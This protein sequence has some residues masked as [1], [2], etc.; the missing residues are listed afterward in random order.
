MYIHCTYTVH[1]VAHNAKLVLCIVIILTTLMRQ[2]R[3]L[4]LHL[5]LFHICFMDHLF[6][7]CLPFFCNYTLFLFSLLTAQ[8]VLEA[9][10]AIINQF[11]TN[12]V[13]EEFAGTGSIVYKV[14]KHQ[15]PVM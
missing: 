6:V 13:I 3:Q 11:D 9:L 4:S 5:A 8:L 10:S 7:C 15:K 2:S 1:S 14:K 12:P